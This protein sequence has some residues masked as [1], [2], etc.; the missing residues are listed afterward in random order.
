MDKTIEMNTI[1][2]KKL[3][4]SHE[5]EEYDNIKKSYALLFSQINNRVFAKYRIKKCS[6][7]T[8]G[9]N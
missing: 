2:H 1:L 7:L 5:N 4:K 9:G 8:L 6:I 3:A